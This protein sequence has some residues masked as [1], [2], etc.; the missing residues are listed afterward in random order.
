MKNAK[1]AKTLDSLRTVWN[2]VGDSGLLQENLAKVGIS[3]EITFMELLYELSDKL[4]SPKS[5][6]ASAGDAK[7]RGNA[8]SELVGK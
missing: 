1:E 7:K 5:N 8:S 2:E 3:P 6:P 4:G